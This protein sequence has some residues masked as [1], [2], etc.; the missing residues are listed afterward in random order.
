M[1]T[2][3]MTIL[4]AAAALICAPRQAAAAVYAVRTTIQPAGG[5]EGFE[6]HW[7]G[8]S[9]RIYFVQWSADLVE[10]R[11]FPVVEYGEAPKTFGFA[12]DSPRLFVRLRHMH[13]LT[14]DP[15][16]A[17]IDGDGLGNLFEV[18]NGFDPFERDTD[19]DG[20]P[21]GAGDE[22][23]DGSLN[24]SEQAAGRNPRIKDNPKVKLS[25]VAGN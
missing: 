21:D 23:R 10:W 8:E 2:I 6:L 11:Y 17:D 16:G 5:T 4:C 15:E 13:Y 14:S 20:T 22:D 25:V 3:P 12:A 24:I 18:M 9:G 1:K 7:T 19:G